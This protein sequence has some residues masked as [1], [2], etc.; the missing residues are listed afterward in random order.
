MSIKLNCTYLVLSLIGIPAFAAYGEPS[1]S[2]FFFQAPARKAVGTLQAGYMSRTYKVTDVG[3]ASDNGLSQAG[4]RY[5]YGINEDLSIEGAV[6]YSLRTLSP[7]DGSKDKSHVNGLDDVQLNLKGTCAGT[8]W[9][10]RYGAYNSIGIG[11]AGDSK[12]S[13][14]A[15]AGSNYTASTGSYTFTPYAGFDFDVSQGILGAKASYD[16]IKHDTVLHTS[17]DPT[18]FGG[19]QDF[20]VTAFYELSLEPSLIGVSFS[21][22]NESRTFLGTES[23]SGW[24]GYGANVY[25]RFGYLNNWQII[26]SFTYNWSAT[27]TNIDMYTANDIDNENDW[28]ADLKVRYTF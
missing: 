11:P 12:T 27:K 2:E 10:W 8:G 18:V 14:G 4:V 21:Y 24:S 20:I 28:R 16:L 25:A 22:I 6:T 3:N 26:P 15:N 19:G 7:A 17:G 13:G 23:Q 9:R 5:E 1:P